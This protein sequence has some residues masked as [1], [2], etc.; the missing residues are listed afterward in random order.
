MFLP[1]YSPDQSWFVALEVDMDAYEELDESRGVWID[2]KSSYVI[3]AVHKFL[4]IGQE[5]GLLC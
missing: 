3:K 2:D 4:P 5:K 1:P